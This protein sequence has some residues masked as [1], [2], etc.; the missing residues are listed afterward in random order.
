MTS[1]A[2]KAISG[3]AFATLLPI[4]LMIVSAVVALG[5]RKR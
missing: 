2:G 5:L 3:A 4:A 1:A